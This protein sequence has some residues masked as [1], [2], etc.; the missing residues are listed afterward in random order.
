MTAPHDHPVATFQAEHCLILSVLDAVDREADLLDHGKAIDPIFWRHACRFLVEYCHGWHESREED[1][2]IRPVERVFGPLRALKAVR[3]DHERFERMIQTPCDSADAGDAVETAARAHEL[4]GQFRSH[5]HQEQAVLFPLARE[6]V[7]AEE[8][9]DALALV[10]EGPA[11]R[12]AHEL[13]D[14]ARTVIR[15]VRA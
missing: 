9:R 8:L 13:E 14:L 15:S 4:A 2:L 1:L 10:G 6:H 12:R 11:A 3:E 7:D 5:I